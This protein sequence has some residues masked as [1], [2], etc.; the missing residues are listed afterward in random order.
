MSLKAFSDFSTTVKAA[1]WSQ[2]ARATRDTATKLRRDTQRAERSLKEHRRLDNKWGNGYA[3]GETVGVESRVAKLRTD[4]EV[5]KKHLDNVMTSNSTFP[6][7]KE[8]AEQTKDRFE[9]K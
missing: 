5:L 8:Y 3:S 2:G 4:G 6:S 7:Q 9:R 1:S